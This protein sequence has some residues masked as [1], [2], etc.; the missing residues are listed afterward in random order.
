MLRGAFFACVLVRK[1]E[2]RGRL[3]TT[4]F[5]AVWLQGG[6]HLHF[7][8]C[9][10]NKKLTPQIGQNRAQVIF[11]L[12]KAHHQALG[13]QPQGPWDV[14]YMRKTMMFERFGLLLGVILFGHKNIAKQHATSHRPVTKTAPEVWFYS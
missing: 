11:F 13:L 12:Y 8:K 5:G 4:N 9:L 1:N 2:L 14:F 10:V 6:V 3:V 7:S